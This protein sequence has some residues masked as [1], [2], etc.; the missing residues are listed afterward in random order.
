M[1]YFSEADQ[2]EAKDMC[3]NLITIL[4]TDTSLLTHFHK[5]E[6]FDD[7]CAYLATFRWS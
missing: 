3:V 2:W 6:W 5:I 1:G 7:A 4:N